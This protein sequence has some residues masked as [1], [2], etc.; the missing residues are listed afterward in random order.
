MKKNWIY[1]AVLFPCIALLCGCTMGSVTRTS[2]QS[3]ESTQAASVQVFFEKPDRAHFIIGA[4]SCLAGPF[5]AEE[6]MYRSLKKEASEIGADGVIVASDLI[7]P[8][9]DGFRQGKMLK[10]LAFRW[11]TQI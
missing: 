7:V 9:N 6:A 8:Y 11:G 2:Q 1:F 4:V 10:G 3:F 5:A